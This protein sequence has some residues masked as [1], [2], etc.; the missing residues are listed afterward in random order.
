VARRL[1]ITSNRKAAQADI[2]G[3]VRR[4]KELLTHIDRDTTVEQR[5]WRPKPEAWSIVEIVQHVALA[6]GGMFR[7][8]HPTSPSLRWKGVLKSALMTGVLRSRIKVRA[9]VSAIVPRPGVTWEEARSRMTEAVAKWAEFVDADSFD[10]TAFKHPLTG[11]LTAAQTARFVVEHF[12]HH[13]RQIDRLFAEH[14]A[15]HQP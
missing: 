13:V 2:A 4:S 8:T 1:S 12:D 5:N 9:P 7:T 15:G 11:R 14:V 10:A 3:L 6:T